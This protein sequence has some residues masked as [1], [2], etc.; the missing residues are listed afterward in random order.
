MKIKLVN[1]SKT[2]LFI[3]KKYL[4]QLITK[5]PM[6][7]FKYWENIY[8]VE[9][10]RMYKVIIAEYFIDQEVKILLLWSKS[11]ST[12][13]LIPFVVRFSPIYEVIR[14][15]FSHHIFLS[16]VSSSIRFKLA[17]SSFTFA[18]QVFFGLTLCLFPSTS[19]SLI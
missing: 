3:L 12:Y 8:N 10:I 5:F 13:V 2:F 4:F 14:L 15:I 9:Y 17:K 7:W 16:Y 1:A 19:N 11:F 6:N 18:L